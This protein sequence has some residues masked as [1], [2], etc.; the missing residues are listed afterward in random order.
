VT[1]V[2]WVAD[3]VPDRGGGGGNIRQAHLLRALAEV[4]TTDAVVV[5][6]PMDPWVADGL[7]RVVE[8]P[9]IPAQRRRFPPR[10][11]QQLVRSLHPAS[12]AELDARAAC[13]AL[14]PHVGDGTG[15]DVVCVQHLGP[16]RLLPATHAARWVLHLFHVPSV[17]AR[18]AAALAKG[19]QRWRWEREATKAARFERWAAANFDQVITVT[20]A[21]AAALPGTPDVVPN[22]VDLDKY[23]MSELPATPTMVT[24]GRLAYPPNVDGVRWLCDDVLPLVQTRCRDATLSIVGHQPDASVMALGRRPGVSVAPDVPDVV[25]FLAGARVVIVPLRIGTGTRLKALEGLA[26]GRPVVGTTVGLEG[27]GL[28]NGTHAL[29]ADDPREL[30]DAVVRVLTDD[31]LARRL[32]RAGRRFVAERFSWSRQAERFVEAVLR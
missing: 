15:Y 21:D 22:G 8:L 5:G 1:T 3:E 16:A 6:G 25:P 24:V 20:D 11:V 23:E 31:E 2:L 4:A 17:Q 27:L 30:A 19:R 12:E 29:I 32:G 9:A 28:E 7:R 26:A 18:S 14:A 13:R 10:R